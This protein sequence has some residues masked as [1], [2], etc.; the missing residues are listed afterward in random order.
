M[1]MSISSIAKVDN[2]VNVAA[3]LGAREAL[4]KAPKEA[5]CGLFEREQNHKGEHRPRRKR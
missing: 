4:E 5:A 3:L 2:G 1:T